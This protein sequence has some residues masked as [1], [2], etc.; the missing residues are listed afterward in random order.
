[1]EKNNGRW[2]DNNTGTYF[3]RDGQFVNPRFRSVTPVPSC[4]VNFLQ[5]VDENKA[6]LIES[7]GKCDEGLKDL[8]EG[9]DKWE[10]VG[11]AL[12]GVET[13]GKYVK[14]LLWLTPKP[15]QETFDKVLEWDERIDNVHGDIDKI[16]RI[17]TSNHPVEDC[18][19]KGLT[20]VLE[21][22]PVIGPSYGQIAAEIPNFAVN[23]Q[24]FA[25]G[26]WAR[27]G[28]QTWMRSKRMGQMF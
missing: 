5:A 14:P 25:D 27:R 23:M 7:L 2:R 15:L 26:Y 9:S 16:I 22:V 13:Y 11:K 24:A 21:Y 12:K 3:G 1:L 17:G 20:A 10:Q 18:V 8:A 4:A 28:M 19:F 6:R